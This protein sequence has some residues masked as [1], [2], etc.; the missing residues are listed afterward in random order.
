ML[1]YFRLNDPYR[2]IIIFILLL[3]IRLPVMLSD[4]ALTMPEL[5]YMLVGERMNDGASLYEG[6]WDNIAPLS[7][8]VYMTIDFFFGRSQLAYQIIALLLVAFQC[9]IFNRLLLINK[10]YN[11]N[12]YVPGLIYGLLMS[13]SFDFLTLTPVLM[14]ITFLLL[15]LNNIFSHIEYRA[16]QDESILNIGLFLGVAYLFYLPSIIFGVATLLIFSFFTGTVGRRYL[17]MVFG[18]ILPML[19][20]ASY[21]LLVGRVQVFVYNFLNPL[22]DY[23]VQKYMSFTGVL[24]LFSVPLLFLILSL[25]RISQRARFTNYQVRL[26]QVMFVWIIFSAG[27]VFLSGTLSPNIFT[28][29]VPSAAFFL[30]HYFLLIKKRFVAELAFLAF[31]TSV[32]LFNLG[33]YFNFFISMEHLDF[34][35]YLVEDT[36]EWKN[37][38]VLVLDDNLQPYVNSYPA[39]PFLNWQL[40]EEL[41][42][43]PEYYDNLTIL[44]K[45]FANDMPEVIIDEHQVLPSVFERLPQIQ[46]RYEEARENVYYLKKD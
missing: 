46:N 1:N 16:K 32:I 6:V 45:G 10:A 39:T 2:L 34:R 21:F 44:Q 17:L 8:F 40:S 30:S 31:F 23:E 14:S 13:F 35:N 19:L 11:E 27:F 38:R 4:D 26:T 15:G 5:N 20:A 7:A 42:R 36:T 9:L 41:F 24:I 25:V 22:L 18:F 3:A 33:I 43:Y 29:F 37:K 12:T 28:V